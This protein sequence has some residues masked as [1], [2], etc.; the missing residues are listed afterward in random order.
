[1][2]EHFKK[3]PWVLDAFEYENEGHLMGNLDSNV[4]APA[5]K[6][7]KELTGK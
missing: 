6:K 3:F 4:I 7:A 2:F 5:E 1:M